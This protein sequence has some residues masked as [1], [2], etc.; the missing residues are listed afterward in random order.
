MSLSTICIKRPVFTIVMNFALTFVGAICLARLPVRELPDI[1]PPIVSVS[2]VY[3]GASAEVVETE[4]TE[5]IEE[6]IN[7]IEGIKTI[8][9]ESREQVSNISVEFTLNRDIELAAQD[10]RDRVSRVRGRLPDTINDPTI[11]KEEADT[12]PMLW[13]ALSSDRYDSVALTKIA[14][15]QFKEPL[16]IVDGVSSIMIGGEKRFAIRIRIDPL[17]MAAHHVTLQDIDNA[18]KDQNIELPSGRIEGLDK[19][20]SITMKGR[21]LTDEEFNNIIIKRSPETLVRLKDIGYAENGVENEYGLSRYSGSSSIGLGVIRQSQSDITKVVDNVLKKLEQIKQFVPKGININVAY[22][23][24]KFIRKSIK[25]VWET[26]FIAFGLVIITIYIFLRD[27]RS[28]FIPFLTIP[29]SIIATFAIFGLF[30]FS[31]NTLTML[32]LVLA[33]GIVVDDSI[34]V[35][36]NIYRHIE[37]GE[38]P[39]KAAVLAMNEITFA[40]I[41]TTITLVVI[42]IPMGFQSGFTGRLFIEFAMAIAGSVLVS[43][44]VAL[45]LTPMAGAKLL[46][47]ID[48]KKENKFTKYLN[49]QFDKLGEKYAK[50]L[51]W[52]IEQRNSIIAFMFLSALLSYGLFFLLPKEFMPNEDK[53]RFL[54]ILNGTEG[55]TAN[56][57]NKE[58]K[59]GEDI[60][61]EIP[62]VEGYMA[63]IAMGRNSSPGRNNMAIMFT[64][65]KEERQRNVH[66]ILGG[67]KGL[68]TRFF[69]EI[70][71]AI[72]YPI[73]PKAI[74][75]GMRQEFQLV[76]KYR[77]LKVLNDY[78]I[79]LV[80]ELTKMGILKSIRARFNLNKP[81][82]KLTID[83]D[84]AATL[85]I[86]IQDL[87]RTLQVLFGGLDLTRITKDGKE[88]LVIV[89]LNRESRGTADDLDNIYIRNNV[90]E[91]IQ[92]SSV[93]S[94]SQVSGP[95]SIYHYNR[96][97]SSTIEG[98]PSGKSIGE[99][100][101]EVETFLAKDLPEGFT[102]E[103]TGTIK[104]MNEAGSD[105]L[106]VVVLALIATYLVLAAQFESWSD[107]F[108]VMLVVPL[109][110]AGAFLSLYLLNLVNML[111]ELFYVMANYVPDPSW[112]AKLG[113][114]LVPRIPAMNMNLFSQIGLL[115]LMGLVTKNSILIVEFANQLVEKGMD[116]KE[117]VMTSAKIRFRPILMTS[118]ATIMGILPIAIGLGAGAT[119]RRPMGVV[120]VG[121]LLVSTLLTLIIIPPLYLMVK[122]FVNFVNKN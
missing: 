81:E 16:Q 41:A 1:D 27:W 57:M 86:S 29:V 105:T 93:V 67:P 61:S 76:I 104:D 75:R 115:L 85:G 53:G 47:H 35:V 21:M 119:S 34:V 118:F 79:H 48:H 54:V 114:N 96:L 36:E 107:P 12:S 26:L 113:A 84:R 78:T 71:G 3:E 13:I 24:S 5:R 52:A 94:H 58:L 80:K 108:I 15:E 33:I 19:E 49:Q 120:V 72:A 117:A 69:N 46:K 7:S 45:T 28:T 98:A 18:L 90:G 4:I 99:I 59:K 17:R 11:A 38:H 70:H 20:F 44:F 122:K 74:E 6:A 101:N 102:Y 43:A 62:E 103:W 77:E 10:V 32:G 111:G 9:S 97:R 40:V 65:L 100:K 56:Y 42:F 82:L 110:T 55:A 39:Q 87:S 116:L 50:I 25:E 60:L 88:Y 112:W 14:E 73:A 68:G 92:L 31:I 23:E 89:Q 121:G 109:A 83:R 51:N 2:T 30:G 37:R 64:Q 8:T 66:D 63:S 95:S 91:L 106:F 22:D